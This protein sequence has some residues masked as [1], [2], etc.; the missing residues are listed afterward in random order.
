[1]NNKQL[2]DLLKQYP[3]D[4]P[5]YVPWD[6]EGDNFQCTV[7]VIPKTELAAQN[8]YLRFYDIEENEALIIC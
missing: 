5:I 7:G 3:D 8:Q 2:Q 1:M 6:R 4:M